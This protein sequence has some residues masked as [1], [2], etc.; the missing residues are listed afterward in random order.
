V[1]EYAW[2]KAFIE[3]SAHYQ[4]R[5]RAAVPGT[6]TNPTALKTQLLRI[7]FAVRLRCNAIALQ[8]GY[9]SSFLI[10]LVDHKQRHNRMVT[11]SSKATAIPNKSHP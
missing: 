4:A 11:P 3:R 2:L 8:L 5:N 10:V 1:D 6:I 7:T 9:I